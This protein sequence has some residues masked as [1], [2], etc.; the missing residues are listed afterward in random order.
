VQ[1]LIALQSSVLG[2]GP[3]G[4]TGTVGSG[5]AEDRG[6]CHLSLCGPQMGSMP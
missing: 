6:H 4:A 3:P 5:V 2:R 1:P